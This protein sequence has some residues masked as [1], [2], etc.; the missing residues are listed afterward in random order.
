M[1]FSK[2][3][4]SVKQWT[5]KFV[6]KFKAN[7][8][9]VYVNDR[10]QSIKKSELS[11]SAQ[12]ALVS[13]LNKKFKYAKFMKEA[14]VGC[15]LDLS[16]LSTLYPLST[17]TSS[18]KSSLH[19][20]LND[21]DHSDS[22]TDY[23][24]LTKKRKRKKSNQTSS[25]VESIYYKIM[26]LDSE[27]KHFYRM[28]NF[29]IANVVQN[30]YDLGDAII[31]I[32]KQRKLELE[33][34]V[35][36]I[37]ELSVLDQFPSITD[38]IETTPITGAW[39][40]FAVK[41]NRNKVSIR[42]PCIVKGKHDKNKSKK[43]VFEIKKIQGSSNYTFKTAIIIETHGIFNAFE[44]AMLFYKNNPNAK[45]LG[46]GHKTNTNNKNNNSDV[47]NALKLNNM[48]F[49]LFNNQVP[50]KQ[51]VDDTIDKEPPRKKQ[52]TAKQPIPPSIPPAIP[53]IPL[54][55]GTNTFNSSNNNGNKNNSGLYNNNSAMNSSN[56]NGN[57]NNSGLYNNNSA[58]NSS[59]NNG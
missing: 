42:V 24:S 45:H 21:S 57:K 10:T 20:I 47:M 19:T 51:M 6:C 36:F 53:P 29:N 41:Q 16:S 26:G 28:D 44:N 50:Q 12:K 43:Y 33:S 35:S 2:S 15:K 5:I 37:R 40:T 27:F 7:D 56:N 25:L 30:G 17:P 23:E 18:S 54:F 34:F 48:Q 39:A 55:H 46:I 59:N 22:S 32:C 58:M 4:N 8:I 3:A 38:E 49:D 31:E 11:T 52:K 13:N 9:K 1:S 14:T